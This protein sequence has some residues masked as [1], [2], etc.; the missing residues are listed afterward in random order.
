MQVWSLMF[1][2]DEKDTELSINVYLIHVTNS[3]FFISLL[4]L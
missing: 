1:I 3:S 2:K 4:S